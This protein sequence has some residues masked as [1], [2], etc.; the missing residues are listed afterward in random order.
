[1]HTRITAVAACVS[2]KYQSS[3]A[4]TE[5]LTTTTYL[6]RT[7]FVFRVMVP[8]YNAPNKVGAFLGLVS[9]GL[10]YVGLRDGGLLVAYPLRRG[11]HESVT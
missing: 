11:K 7:T 9:L 8:K 5:S 3:V 10:F 6:T 4:L 2:Q 1:M